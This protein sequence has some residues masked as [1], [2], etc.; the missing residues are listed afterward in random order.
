MRVDQLVLILVVDLQFVSLFERCFHSP[1]GPYLDKMFSIAGVAAS[2]TAAQSKCLYVLSGSSPSLL[3]TL[4][5]AE[6]IAEM[7]ADSYTNA[8]EESS[9]SAQETTCNVER[10]VC[11]ELHRHFTSAQSKKMQTKVSLLILQGPTEPLRLFSCKDYHDPRLP[12]RLQIDVHTV[13]L[14]MLGSLHS[15]R[16]FPARK[17]TNTDGGDTVWITER[18]DEIPSNRMSLLDDVFY[19]F[20]SLS[21]YEIEV[22]DRCAIRFVASSFTHLGTAQMGLSNVVPV[23]SIQILP[24]TTTTTT[25]T[26]TMKAATATTATTANSATNM[27]SQLAR[28][29]DGAVHACLLSLDSDA[30]K[31]FVSQCI[32]NEMCLLLDEGSLMLQFVSQTELLLTRSFTLSNDAF[33]PS[34]SLDGTVV[35]SFKKEASA[36]SSE[37]LPWDLLEKYKDD[38]KQLPCL[39]DDYQYRYVSSVHQRPQRL[40]LNLESLRGLA[41]PQLLAHIYLFNVGDAPDLA[42]EPNP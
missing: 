19:R 27:A 15:T 14:S 1:F 34:F 31:S 10:L 38:C 3:H 23:S 16:F 5:F 42:Q 20:F 21:I 28:R 2:S 7:I 35:E 11:T 32:A 6:Q 4:L 26:T 17:I 33:L 8:L 36:G 37:P 25:T 30:S 29:S 39:R 22:K 24:G 40:Q 9:C 12:H 18:L 13:Q 41:L